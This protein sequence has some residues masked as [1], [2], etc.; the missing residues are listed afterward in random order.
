MRLIWDKFKYYLGASNQQQ[1]QSRHVEWDRSCPSDYN[2]TLMQQSMDVMAETFKF[3]GTCAHNLAVVTYHHAREIDYSYYLGLAGTSVS[4]LY[5]GS[6]D[7]LNSIK[8]TTSSSKTKC[9]T[10]YDDFPRAKVKTNDEFEEL[11]IICNVCLEK[12]PDRVL[13]PCGHTYCSTC[14]SQITICP[15]CRSS[16]NGTMRIYLC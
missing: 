7:M 4:Y 1:H 3:V 10:T 13:I 15:N 5:N 11:E 6:L 12:I 9:K 8:Q 16:I 14:L 2:G